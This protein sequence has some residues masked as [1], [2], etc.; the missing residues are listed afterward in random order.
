[1]EREKEIINGN[2]SPEAVIDYYDNWADHGYDEVLNMFF[3]KH[4]RMYFT[5]KL[6]SDLKYRIVSRLVR[7]NPKNKHTICII[8]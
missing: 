6:K 4:L 8:I 7:L 3:R 1:M 2:I 5:N